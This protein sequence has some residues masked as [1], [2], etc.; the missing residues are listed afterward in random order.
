MNTYKNLALALCC[1]G[2]LFISSC[3][4]LDEMNINPNGIDPSIANPSQ[5]ISTVISGTGKTVTGQGFGDMSVVMQ[6]TQLDGWS[7]NGYS[8][9]TSSHDGLWG[10][11][12]SNLRNAKELMTKAEETDNDFFRGTALIFMAYNWGYLADMWGDVPF[13]EALRNDEGIMNPK[14]DSQFDIYKGILDYLEQANTLL[15]KP[16]DE[17]N[18]ISTTQDILY[19]GDVAKW[20][21]FANSLAL[22]YYL[23]L[24]EKEPEFA[25]TGIGKIVGNESMYPLI[26]ESADDASFAYAGNNSSSSWPTNIVGNTDLSSGY[27]RVKLCST[28]VE[29]MRSHNDPRLGVWANPVELPLYLDSSREEWPDDET[30]S[31]EFI[32]DGEKVTK[33]CRVVGSKQVSDYENDVNHP[34][35]PVNFNHDFIGMPPS[36]TIGAEY[37]FNLSTVTYQGRPNMH[38]SMLNDIYKLASHELLKARMLSAS[39][40]RFNLAEIA[41]KGWGG[42]AREQYEA[43]IRTSFESWGVGDRYA[44]FIAQPDVAFDNSL[45]QIIVQKWVASWSAT[46]EAWFD[47]RRTGYPELKPGLR[48]KRAALPI[49]FYYVQNEEQTN[50]EKMRAALDNFE[51]TRYSLEEPANAEFPAMTRNSAWS[52]MWLLQGTNKPW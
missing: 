30:R 2:T 34:G 37:A 20:R 17:Y 26:L 4:D 15:S 21:K 27:H 19:G 36:W 24:S 3:K 12:F 44:D 22:R 45:E 31:V 47:W 32:V 49:R 29:E 46:C 9:Q 38:C 6:H 50:M 33:R 8:W 23:R 40:T 18:V 25:R 41:L 7:N 14:Y 39:E 11:L 1:L 5:L 48:T 43:A 28:L 16:Q 13:S 10:S 51:D 42:N 52:K 35:V